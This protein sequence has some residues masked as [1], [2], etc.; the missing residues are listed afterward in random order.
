MTT[1]MARFP[2]GRPT[3]RAYPQMDAMGGGMSGQAGQMGGIGGGMQGGMDGQLSGQSSVPAITSQRP[4]GGVY[5]NQW[6]GSAPPFGSGSPGQAPGLTRPMVMGGGQPASTPGQPG[7]PQGMPGGG[8]GAGGGMPMGGMGGGMGTMPGGQAGG[9]GGG[10]PGGMNQGPPQI[11]QVDGSPMGGIGMPGGAQPG[12]PSPVFRPATST[13]SGPPSLTGGPGVG[14]VNP[15]GVMPGG[16]PGPMGGGM[17]PGGGMGGGMPGPMGGGMTP[18][19]GMG[20]GPTGPGQMNTDPSTGAQV[21]PRSNTGLQAHPNAGQPGFDSFGQPIAQAPSRAPGGGSQQSASINPQMGGARGQPGFAGQIGSPSHMIS[22]NQSLPMGTPPVMESLD[23]MKQDRLGKWGTLDRSGMDQ[24]PDRPVDATRD[25][26]DN[27]LKRHRELAKWKAEV[28]QNVPQDLPFWDQQAWIG[29]QQSQG[30]DQIF[31]DT[32]MNPQFGDGTPAS[33]HQSLLDNVQVGGQFPMSSPQ[34]SPG[35]QPQQQRISSGLQAPEGFKPETSTSGRFKKSTTGQWFDTRTGRTFD[36][37][38][39]EPYQ[40]T[41]TSIEG[42]GGSYKRVNSPLGRIAT[43]LMPDIQSALKEGNLPRARELN[44]LKNDMFNSMGTAGGNF[45]SINGWRDRVAGMRTPPPVDGTVLGEGE[46][47]SAAVAGG[48]GS[49]IPSPPVASTP[50]S[51][52]QA[53]VNRAFT[54]PRLDTSMYTEGELAGDDPVD[55][56]AVQARLEGRIP[57]IPQQRRTGSQ[58]GGTRATRRGG[59]MTPGD[60]ISDRFDSQYPENIVTGSSSGSAGWQN[61]K[62]GSGSAGGSSTRPLTIPEN[63]QQAVDQRREEERKR[64]ETIRGGESDTEAAQ[65]GYLGRQQDLSQGWRNR[66]ANVLSNLEGLGDSA[67]QDI[68][69][70]YQQKASNALQN[71]I[72]RGL[73]GTTVMSALDRGLREG[74]STDMRRLNEML[75][76]ERLNWDA[77]TAADAL[78]YDERGTGDTLQFMERLN[79]PYPDV[80][81]Y[82]QLA[83]QFGQ[84]GPGGGGF[85]YQP[86]QQPNP[87]GFIPGGGGGFGGGGQPRPQGPMGGGGNLPPAQPL[88]PGGV[89]QIPGF[90]NETPPWNP[91]S[92]YS[93]GPPAGFQPGGNP[94]NFPPAQPGPNVAGISP[95]VLPPISGNPPGPTGPSGSPTQAVQSV[96]SL[97]G[98]MQA[99]QDQGLDAVMSQIANQLGIS[100]AAL[101]DHFVTELP[102]HPLSQ[103]LRQT[104]EGT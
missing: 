9:M 37:N 98:G 75:R 63:F 21:S 79:Q 42:D 26:W 59:P 1:M 3:K 95:N 56:E 99:V 92:P 80:G 35:G 82:L 93:Q 5:Q 57:G 94:G 28:Q 73:T 33:P 67:R 85:N 88:P 60:I 58:A 22:P 54:S 49:S 101:G 62:P 15:S 47:R 65:G 27:R 48:E 38:P 51:L 68:S 19:G 10:M 43:S 74:E 90:L 2:T 4:G 41:Q 69:Q 46:S 18:G 52:R 100:V 11:G 97:M 91:Q 78:N 102:D 29:E 72:S 71:M 96:F 8:M 31:G 14:G 7:S 20:G 81:R 45:Q 25:D 64:Y 36:R 34:A 6:G 30:Q 24:M 55:R 12:S 13:Q 53:A 87:F 84:A 86:A 66:R 83:G 104:M 70:R 17:V 50:P 89:S 44:Q 40:S 103:L 23:Q 77:N 39:E 61:I 32:P 16:Q 76:R